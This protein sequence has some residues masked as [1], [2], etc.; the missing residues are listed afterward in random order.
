MGTLQHTPAIMMQKKTPSMKLR[1]RGHGG[2]EKEAQETTP[3]ELENYI[4]AQVN[5]PR[6]GGMM[7]GT[8]KCRAGTGDGQVM[9]KANDN[10][11]LDTR[12]Y[13]VKFPDGYESLFMANL[14]A[15]NM[16]T[17]CDAHGNQHLLFKAIVDHSYDESAALGKKTNTTNKRQPRGGHWWS[18]GKMVQSHGK[19]FQTSKS[20]FPLK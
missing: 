9:G 17:Q 10:P 16:Y 13:I 19:D 6:Q 1:E 5:L 20:H 15:E 4:G 18:N 11:I 3:E 8:I 7:S 14:I 12:K 2:Q